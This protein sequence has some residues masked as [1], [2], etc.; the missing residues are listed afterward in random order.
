MSDATFHTSDR[1]PVDDDVWFHVVINYFGAQAGQ[2]FVLY[3]NGRQ[4]SE[5]SERNSDD[6][7]NG[8]GSGRIVIGRSFTDVDDH[9]SSMAVDELLLFNEFLPA[10]VINLLYSY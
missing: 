10:D 9:Y 2:G 5:N 8:L 6:K 4:V 7:R 3:F 1:V